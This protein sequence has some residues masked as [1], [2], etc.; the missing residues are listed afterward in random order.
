MVLSPAPP[1]LPGRVQ[2]RGRHGRQGT[3][4]SRSITEDKESQIVAESEETGFSDDS[5]KCVSL[6]KSEREI[7]H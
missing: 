6:R 3:E 7:F 1:S 2:D 5:W 4:R